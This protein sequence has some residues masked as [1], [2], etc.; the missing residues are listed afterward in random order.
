MFSDE[1]PMYLFYEQNKKND[2]V[3]ESQEDKVPVTKTVK[4]RAYV[5]I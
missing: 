2:I 3:W 4:K 1:S 5:N